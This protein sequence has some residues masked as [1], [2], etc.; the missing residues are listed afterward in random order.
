MLKVALTGNIGSGKSTVSHLFEI[1]GVP[2]FSADTAGHVALRLPEVVE[3]LTKAFG[4]DFIDDSG[5]VNR[6][7]LGGI[8]FPDPEKLRE[9][10]RITHPEIKK[11]MS[12]WMDSHKATAHYVLC[13][14]A[15]L[16]EGNF[17]SGFDKI[18]TVAA[19]S[20]VDRK[21]VV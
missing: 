16:F 9:L 18:I 19:P 8:V 13:E 14:V 6:K 15:V 5:A 2:V 4:N 17:E 7:I 21:S 11:I 1:L 3:Q 12:S 10:N 20:D